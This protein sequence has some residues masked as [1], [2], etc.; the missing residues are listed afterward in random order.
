ML[1]ILSNEDSYGLSSF[2]VSAR[3]LPPPQSGAPKA[4]FFAPSAAF[5]RKSRG[6]T[7]HGPTSSQ[8]THPA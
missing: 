4:P 6:H 5:S 1:P 3:V 7:H 2:L 8:A